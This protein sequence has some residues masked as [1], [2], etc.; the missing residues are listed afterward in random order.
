MEAGHVTVTL[1]LGA[2][3][4]ALH[5]PR[6]VPRPAELS[7]VLLELT[8]RPR[9]RRPSGQALRKPPAGGAN[10]LNGPTQTSVQQLGPTRPE[11]PGV[12][13]SGTHRS[14]WSGERS[15]AWWLHGPRAGGR[16][17]SPVPAVTE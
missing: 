17:R 11:A 10:N 16:R 12:A 13:R 7:G 3:I 8:E 14:E 1:S 6:H 2:R 9:S 4:E 5:M 15:S